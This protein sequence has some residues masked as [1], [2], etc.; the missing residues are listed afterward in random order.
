MSF[1][2]KG[3]NLLLFVS[4]SKSLILF[5]VPLQRGKTNEPTYHSYTDSY[6]NLGIGLVCNEPNNR[7]GINKLERLF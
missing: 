7:F 6:P 2:P 5:S 3:V 1:R 4:P